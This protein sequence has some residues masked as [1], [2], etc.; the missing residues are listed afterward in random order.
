MAQPCLVKPEKN[1]K[2]KNKMQ[3]MTISDILQNYLPSEQDFPLELKEHIASSCDLLLS[4]QLIW[5]IDQVFAETKYRVLANIT[6]KMRD[7]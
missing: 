5:V 7:F 6:E 1:L 4:D 3:E 2:G